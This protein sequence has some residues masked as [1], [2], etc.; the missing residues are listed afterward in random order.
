MSPASPALGSLVCPLRHGGSLR[1]MSAEVFLVPRPL[2]ATAAVQMVPR[3]L[4]ATAARHADGPGARTLAGRSARWTRRARV[5]P[6]MATKIFCAAWLGSGLGLVCVCTAPGRPVTGSFLG[7]VGMVGTYTLRQTYV[8]FRLRPRL[9]SPPPA[10]GPSILA[11]PLRPMASSHELRPDGRG[12]WQIVR[13]IVPAGSGSR[14]L[15]RIT[16][17]WM[18][19]TRQ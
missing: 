1:R 7:S 18:L 11:A 13:H 8:N 19:P 12:Q 16:R 17:C 9:V 10:R 5:K 14:L 4:D 15:R 2:D 6:A 3:P